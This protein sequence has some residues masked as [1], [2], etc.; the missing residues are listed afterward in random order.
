MAFPPEVVAKVGVDPATR[1]YG[2]S[3]GDLSK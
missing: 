3:R 2:T 1:Y